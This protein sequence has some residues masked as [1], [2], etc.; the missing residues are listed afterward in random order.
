[1]DQYKHVYSDLYIVLKHNN[2][3]IHGYNLLEVFFLEY[4]LS[5]HLSNDRIKEIYLK[6]IISPDPKN[7][8]Q[9]R[10]KEGR[11]IECVIEDKKVYMFDARNERYITKVHGFKSK[12]GEAHDLTELFKQCQ[13][14]LIDSCMTIDICGKADPTHEG[15][16][17]IRPFN[18]VAARAGI[19]IDYLD[20]GTHKTCN[21]DNGYA[22]AQSA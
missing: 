8:E 21:G 2:F 1:V 16:I 18:L 11:V 5:R 13:D 6:Q 20:A 4:Y 7:A 10:N 22:L 14:G 15:L 9:Q 17:R 19:Q 12:Y 3:S